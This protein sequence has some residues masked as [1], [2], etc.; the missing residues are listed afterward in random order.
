MRNRQGWEAGHRV[1]DFWCWDHDV[2][3]GQLQGE[4]R[5]VS[6]AERVAGVLEMLQTGSQEQ[7]TLSKHLIGIHH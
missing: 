6:S 3:F 1:W 5:G 7:S 4:M 2:E